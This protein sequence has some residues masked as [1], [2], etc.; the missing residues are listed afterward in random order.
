MTPGALTYA[1]RD[2]L[3]ERFG[4]SLGLVTPDEAGEI[5]ESRGVSSETANSLRN[6]LQR[7]E[8][9]VYSGK[10][11]DPYDMGDGIVN[12]IR[13]IERELR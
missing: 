4:L 1:L 11:N 6:F 9:T 7:L 8:D 12:V 5:L 2:Y 13:R 10:G 3:N